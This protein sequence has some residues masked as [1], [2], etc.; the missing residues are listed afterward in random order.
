VFP[1]QIEK[2]LLRIEGIEPHYQIIVTRP[3]LMD[4]L[5]VRVETSPEL[6][7]DDIRQMVETRDR[8]EEFIENEIGLRVKVTLVEPGTIPRSEGKAVRVIDKRNL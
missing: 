8:I 2:A 6:F 1:S 4:E 3:H 7:S 5:E